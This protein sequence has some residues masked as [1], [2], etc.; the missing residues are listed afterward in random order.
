MPSL[1]CR[2]LK[3]LLDYERGKPLFMRVSGKLKEAWRFGP[4]GGSL[5][6]SEHFYALAEALGPLNTIVALLSQLAFEGGFE[7]THAFVDLI[8]SDD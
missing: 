1:Y 7:D 4:R 3:G 6:E 2:R 5:R 8:V